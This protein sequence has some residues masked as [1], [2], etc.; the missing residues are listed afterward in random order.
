AEAQGAPHRARARAQA[1]V[2]VQ[3]G[4]SLWS[5]AAAHLPAD[6]TASDVAAA[7][8][9]WYQANADVIGVDPDEI[10]PGQRLVVPD[11]P[12]VDATRH[13][14]AAGGSR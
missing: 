11:A 13:D 3:R 6:A 7:W 10:R 4:D 5:I 1:S 12:A 9:T 14:A 2:V 8:P